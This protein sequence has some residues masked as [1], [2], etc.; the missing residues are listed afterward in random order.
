M[1]IPPVGSVVLLPFPY[2]D[3]SGYKRRPALVVGHAEFGNVIIC[4]ITSKSLTSKRA[5]RLDPSD[6][7]MGELKL[8]SYVRPDKLFTLDTKLIQANLAYLT[9]R[10]QEEVSK[11]IQSLF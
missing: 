6:L 7:E 10:K 3:F 4:Q 2:A 5:I 1:G 8:M 9:L 11:T